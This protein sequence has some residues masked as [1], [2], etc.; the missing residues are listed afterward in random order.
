MG[1][2]KVKVITNLA[3]SCPPT[4]ITSAAWSMRSGS[5]EKLVIVALNSRSFFFSASVRPGPGV[6]LTVADSLEERRRTISVAKRVHR[7]ARRG[8]GISVTALRSG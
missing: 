6:I 3:P 2:L 4:P 1:I 5:S 7:L 8:K